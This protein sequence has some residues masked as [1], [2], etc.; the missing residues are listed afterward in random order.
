MADKEEGSCIIQRK[1]GSPGGIV[2]QQ[3]VV[4]VHRDPTR[5]DAT[6]R[7]TALCP[8]PFDASCLPIPQSSPS[9]SRPAT[10]YTTVPWFLSMPIWHARAFCRVSSSFRAWTRWNYVPAL[11]ELLINLKPKHET[12]N[13]FKRFSKLIAGLNSASSLRIKLR[14]IRTYTRTWIRLGVGVVGS[15]NPTSTL[16]FRAGRGSPSTN[17]SEFGI[18][19]WRKT[20]QV[21]IRAC[22]SD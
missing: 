3:P 21:S 16:R 8:L 19:V 13:V 6:Q 14:W 11:I 18:H 4:S 15:D 2:T 5:H 1:L 22:L 17:V 12:P 7:I 9:H 10:F 20:Q